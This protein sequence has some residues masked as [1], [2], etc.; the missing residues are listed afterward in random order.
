MYSLYVSILP[1]Q[2]NALQRFHPFH[3]SFHCSSLWVSLTCQELLFC[4]SVLSRKA[5]HHIVSELGHRARFLGTAGQVC[6]LAAFH[7]QLLVESSSL[8]AGDLGWVPGSALPN[9][10]ASGC[11][12]PPLLHLI[13]QED[14][15]ALE[16]AMGMCKMAQ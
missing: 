16:G 3:C 8:Q 14:H 10:V 2:E 15:H 13:W 4:L 9:C 5:A 12:E 1:F 11:P 6:S 7:F